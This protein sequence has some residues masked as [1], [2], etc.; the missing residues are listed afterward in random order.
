MKTILF[1]LTLIFCL[2]VYAEPTCSTKGTKIIYTNGVNTPRESAEFALDNIMA[3][4]IKSQVDKDPNKVTYVVEYNYTESIAKDFLESAVQRFPQSFL[5]GLKISKWEAF[6]RLKSGDLT[7]LSPAILLS[8]EE[9]LIEDTKNYIENRANIAKYQ[10]NLFAVRDSY[11]RTLESG[12]RVFAIS[13]SQGGLFMNE[14]YELLGHA[15][16]DKFFA[17]YQIATPVLDQ[18][19]AL[20]DYSTH[21]KD[22]VINVVRASLGALPPNMTTPLFINNTYNSTEDYFDFILNHGISTTYLYDSTL[23]P[24]IVLKLGEVAGMLRSNCAPVITSLDSTAD[25]QNS[26]KI[27]FNASVEPS[28]PSHIYQWDFGDTTSESSG[29]TTSHT[30]EN[31]GIYNVKLIVTDSG[32]ASSEAKTI[33]VEVKASTV[34]GC[35]NVPGSYFQNNPNVFIANT[36][37]VSQSASMSG[38]IEVCGDSKVLGSTSIISNGGGKVKIEGTAV[39]ENA[40]IS[41]LSSSSNINNLIT[42]GGNAVISGSISASSS[43]PSKNVQLTINSNIAGRLEISDGILNVDEGTTIANSGI[44]RVSTGQMTIKGSNTISGIVSVSGSGQLILEGSNIISGSVGKSGPGLATVKGTNEILGAIG[45]T[46]GSLEVSGSNKILPSAIIISSL[47]GS[48]KFA[49][50]SVFAG[51]LQWQSGNGTLEILGSSNIDSTSTIFIQSG[52]KVTISDSTFLGQLWLIGANSSASIESSNVIG[53]VYSWANGSFT[54]TVRI[55]NSSVFN[56][57]IMADAINYNATATAENAQVYSIIVARS[58]QSEGNAY[59]TGLVI[60]PIRS[61]EFMPGMQTMSMAR[62]IDLMPVIDVVPENVS[63]EPGNDKKNKKNDEFD[64]GNHDHKH[65][66]RR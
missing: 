51:R 19:I 11:K 56:Q 62:T 12:V 43:D 4:K 65:Q 44:V 55:S 60:T 63:R 30:Y 40:N 29:S 5:D 64:H 27:N 50:S 21:D 13:H 52:K 58:I 38:K 8:L 41:L 17:G 20:F 37:E 25:L 32:G 24:Q 28:D 34:L 3:L 39:L 26:L 33:S 46:N 61:G 15:D 7:Q 10:E 42:I 48:I 53:Q 16:K 36:A 9:K 14:A 59:G 22:F 47:E 49:G 54:A 57:L 31:P 45:V 23:K 1:L 2:N 6:S 18:P 35:N 66:K